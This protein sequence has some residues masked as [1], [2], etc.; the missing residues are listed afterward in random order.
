MSFT[1]RPATAADIGTV[2]D[3]AVDMVLSSRSDLRPEVPDVALLEC[4]RR[5]LSQLPEILDLPTGG[6]FVAADEK[7]RPIGHVI[8]MGG[9]MDSVTELPQAWVYDLSVRPE[10]WGKGVGRALMAAAEEFT[11]SLGLEWLGLGVTAS[12]ARAVGF[13]EEIGYR[14]ERIQMAKRLE[15]RAP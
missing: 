2:M 9:N 6:L 4:R 10:W 3:L 13:Y 12:N 11:L 1:I 8:V 7:D 5:N 14:P 15:R